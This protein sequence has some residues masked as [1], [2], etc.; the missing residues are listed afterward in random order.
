M[1]RST[2]FM[3]TIALCVAGTASAGE[4]KVPKGDKARPSFDILSASIKPD[5]RD[6]VFTMALSMIVAGP[7][8]AKFGRRRGVDVQLRRGILMLTAAGPVVALAVC[9]SRFG[10]VSWAVLSVVVAGLVLAGTGI[11]FTQSAAA[12]DIVLSAAGKSG[13]AVGIHNMIRFLA[14]GAGYAVVALAYAADAIL[15]VYP[16]V[17]LAGVAMLITFGDTRGR[18]S[19]TAGVPCPTRETPETVNERTRNDH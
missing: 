16:F 12:T 6:L 15:L 5:G 3:L 17:S 10:M 13:T 14:M 7:L 11:A 2:S 4:I 9:C 1:L 8:A 18:T 19:R